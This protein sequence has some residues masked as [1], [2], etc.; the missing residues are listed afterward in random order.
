VIKYL[1][2]R[3]PNFDFLSDEDRFVIDEG[4]Y[5]SQ[6][7]CFIGHDPGSPCLKSR[8]RIK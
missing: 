1:V 3:P 4:V 6:R 5:R 2:E 7:H 8:R